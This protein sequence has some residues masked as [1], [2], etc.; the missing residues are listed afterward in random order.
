M[1]YL[2]EGPLAE[3][4][5]A[6]GADPLEVTAAEF[7]GRIRSRSARIKALLL[8]QSVLRGAVIFTRTRV[9]G[10]RRFTRHGSAIG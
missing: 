4:L 2:T 5:R 9:C 8:D 7:A 10:A 6:F 1:A 3:E